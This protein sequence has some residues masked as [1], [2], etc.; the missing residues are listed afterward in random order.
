MFKKLFGASVAFC[1]LIALVPTAQAQTK[2][3]D[4]V[5][6]GLLAHDVGFAGGKEKGANVNAE[7]LFASPEFF[8]YILRPRPMVGL[9]INTSGYTS[10]AYAG[11]AWQ[12]TLFNDVARPGDGVYFGYTFG[13]SFNDGKHFS[14][15]SDRKSLGSNL[16]FRES[17]ELGYQ[18]SK[19]H[20]VSAYFDHVSNGGI[21]RYNQS[22]NNLGV[23][24]GL[25]F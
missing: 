6:V 14:T 4:E 7:L 18:L 24:V 22:L 12:W 23:R 2:F 11:L 5:K 20:S 17:F 25:K 13:A 16:L 9:E 19:I 3:L 21:Q 15:K 8:K 1:A 10:Q